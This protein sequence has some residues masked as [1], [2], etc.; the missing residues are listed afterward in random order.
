[1]TGITVSMPTNPSITEDHLTNFT[2]FQKNVRTI[3][4]SLELGAERSANTLIQH[5]RDYI[6]HTSI[7]QIFAS[8]TERK[9]RHA[10][11][12][13]SVHLF[14]LNLNKD[15]FHH[16]ISFI[17]LIDFTRLLILL[18]NGYLTLNYHSFPK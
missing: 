14:I 6:I 16:V 1:M 11:K 18:N 10:R 3:T 17:F 7:R 8:S 5:L 4:K 12:E 15:I 13:N 2:M 9:E